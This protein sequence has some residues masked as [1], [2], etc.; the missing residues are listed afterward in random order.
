MKYSNRQKYH[1]IG[2][3]VAQGKIY[4]FTV[5]H[6]DVELKRKLQRPLR[7]NLSKPVM[8]TVDRIL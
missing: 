5:S 3:V 2:V 1:D 6:S 8:S 7:C 4:L